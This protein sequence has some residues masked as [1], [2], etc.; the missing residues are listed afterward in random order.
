M[1]P[2]L[3]KSRRSAAPSDETARVVEAVWAYYEAGRRPAG[4]QF[5]ALPVE[6][7]EAYETQVSGGPEPGDILESMVTARGQTLSE[8]AEE[9]EALIESIRYGDDAAAAGDAAL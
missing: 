5:A 2:S 1:A 4:T 3:F 8:L 7:P 6:E 9:L